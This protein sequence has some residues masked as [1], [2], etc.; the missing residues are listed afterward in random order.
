MTAVSLPLSQLIHENLSVVLD[1]AFS[2]PAIADMLSRF[3]GDWKYLRRTALEISE[4]RANKSVIELA[5]FLRILDDH[6]ERKISASFT[7]NHGKV[8]GHVSARGSQAASP[9]AIRDA[10]NRIIH[11]AALS[12]DMSDHKR[13]MLTCSAQAGQNWERAQ[14]DLVNVAAFCGA[15]IH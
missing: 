5:L 14:V 12:W 9:L 10:A 2:R 3:D 11:A 4:A 6:V 13:P 7:D 1:F 8:F 15:L